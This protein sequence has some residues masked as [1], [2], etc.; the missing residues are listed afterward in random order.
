MLVVESAA[1]HVS[2]KSLIDVQLCWDLN[3]EGLHIFSYSSNQTS[4]KTFALIILVLS[5]VC[6]N[7]VDQTKAFF[8]KHH[9]PSFVP[10]V[11]FRFILTYPKLCAPL[12]TPAISSRKH[13]NRERLKLVCVNVW[14]RKRPAEVC[15]KGLN[16]KIPYPAHP[17]S[18]AKCRWEHTEWLGA[19][20]LLM[21]WLMSAVPSI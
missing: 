4:K 20:A 9:N 15:L 21:Y 6:N 11:E 19:Q 18:R 13:E 17:V 3:C 12:G 10:Y 14:E 5:H 8:G 1:E 2:P 16:T 7:A